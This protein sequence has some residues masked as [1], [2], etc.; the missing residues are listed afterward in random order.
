MHRDHQAFIQGIHSKKRLRITFF[1]KKDEMPVIRLC[2]PMDFGRSNRTNNLMNRYHFWD[3]EG[4]TKSHHLSLLPE[5]IS[6]MELTEES[7]DPA[8][9]VKWEPHWFILRDWGRFS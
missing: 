9:F 1:S 6:K 8:D 7:F 3:Y 5:N 2:A 4:D